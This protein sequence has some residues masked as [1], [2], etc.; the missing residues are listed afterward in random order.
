MSAAESPRR[1]TVLDQFFVS[2]LWLAYNVQW[3]ALLFVVLPHQVAAIAGPEQKEAALGQLLAIGA[4]VSLVVTPISGALSDRSRSR[5]GRRRPYLVVGVLINL[6]FLAL[7]AGSGPG[8]HLGLFTLWFTGIQLGGNWWGGPYAGLIPDVV[9]AEYR[10]RASGWQAL[11]TALGTIIGA[12]AGAA[13]IGRGGYWGAYAV[14]IGTLVVMLCLTL[15]GVRERPLEEDP[16]PFELGPFVRSFFLSYR[17]HRNFYWVLIT[18]ALVCMGV[19]SVSPYFQYFLKDVIHVANEEAATATLLVIIIGMGIPTSMIAGGLSDRIG[20][21][22]L[23]YLSGSVM[24]FACMV[25]VAVAFFPSLP[26]TYVMAAVYGIGNGAY[27]AVDWALALD[28]LPS[29]EDAAKD[30]GVWHVAL[31]LP[32][33]VAPAITGF[34]VAAIKNAPGGSFLIAYT[35]VF[36]MAAIWFVLG[37]L[38]V[39]QVRGVR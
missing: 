17:E 21:K 26:F 13:L 14:I 27:V 33:I 32:Q 16:G 28:V 10:G 35:V 18:R 2:C 4:A 15:W 7:M 5:M 9:P 37:T 23:V 1:F 20:R 22:P 8:S 29:G 6:L 19:Y 38:L 11:M 24:A 36:T 30:M 34:T 25:Y 31:V 12:V 39:R 3:G